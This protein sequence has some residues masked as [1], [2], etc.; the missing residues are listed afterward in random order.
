[1][2]ARIAT[3]LIAALVALAAV[4]CGS[5]GEDTT[6]LACREGAG[7]YLTALRAAPGEVRV[8][9]ETA[10]SECLSQ[11]Q[12]PGNLATVGGALIEA[13]TRLNADARAEPSGDAAAQLGYL[14]GAVERG[15]AETEGIHSDLVRRLVVAAR[16]APDRDPL[17]Q[18]FQRAYREGFDAG[19]DHG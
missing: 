1:M 15:A 8:G 16:F 12:E 5:Q 10:I 19:R 14:I 4:G 17:S 7:A 3:V 13:A 18:A 11:N 2:R 9:S 6:P